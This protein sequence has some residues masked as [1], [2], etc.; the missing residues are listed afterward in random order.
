MECANSVA[1]RGVSLNLMPQIASTRIDAIKARVSARSATGIGTVR[2]KS[3][4]YLKRHLK[5]MKE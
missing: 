1:G 3:S 2:L 4:S 5:Q